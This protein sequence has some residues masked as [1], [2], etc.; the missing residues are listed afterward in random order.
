MRPLT[1]PVL[2]F[3]LAREAETLRL[4]EG[5]QMHG[6]SAKSL[7]KHRDMRIVL[8]TMKRG[9]RIDEHQTDG[10]VSIHV[11]AGRLAVHAGAKILDAPSGTLLALDRGLPHDLE[12]LEDSTFVLSVCTRPRR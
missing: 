6:H 4:E 3:D 9:T 5:W 12:A 8:I 2:T 7:V 1:R 11:V 10:A